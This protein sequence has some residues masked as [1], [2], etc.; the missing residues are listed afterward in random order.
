MRV[1]ERG[2]YLDLGLVVLRHID[3]LEARIDLVK[4]AVR[5]LSAEKLALLRRVAYI[6]RFTVGKIS[7]RRMLPRRI[8]VS[9]AETGEAVL[10]DG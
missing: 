4:I 1:L 5:N 3:N 8:S 10:G 7:K 9:F 2:D 6:R